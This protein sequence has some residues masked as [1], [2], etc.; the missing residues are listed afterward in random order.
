MQTDGESLQVVQAVADRLER[1]LVEVPAP[2]PH[3]FVVP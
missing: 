2:A 1:W 3:E